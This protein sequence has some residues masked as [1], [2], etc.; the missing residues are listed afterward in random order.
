MVQ[1][2]LVVVMSICYLWMSK[3]ITL[4]SKMGLNVVAV[5]TSISDKEKNGCRLVLMH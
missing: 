3:F 1:V 4:I 5:M 2:V